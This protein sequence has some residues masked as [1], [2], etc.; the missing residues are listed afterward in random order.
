MT[1]GFVPLQ[2]MTISFH[3]AV[4]DDMIT[5]EDPE[6]EVSEDADMDR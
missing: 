1:I 3:D 4:D 5:V 6:K 2:A